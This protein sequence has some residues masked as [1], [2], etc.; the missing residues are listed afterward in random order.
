MTTA[1][2]ALAP[3]RRTPDLEAEQVTQLLPGE[4]VLVR[5]QTEEWSRVVAPWQA[6]SLDPAGYPGWVRRVHLDEEATGPLY[7]LPSAAD[8]LGTARSYL[9]TQYLWGG[10]TADGID[11]SGL[12]HVVARAH[13]MR[14]PRD[15]AD[16]HRRLAR[17]DLDEARVGDVYFFAR[18][19]ARVHHVALVAADAGPGVPRRVLHAPDTG[20][21]RV[22][23]EEVL[24]PERLATLHGAARLA[25]VASV[26]LDAAAG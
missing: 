3:V 18:A 21:E 25:S 17:V 11:C 12:V 6:S 4:P 2:R 10:L 24:P 16:Q 20:A 15:A 1:A 26:V 5:E 22:V 9:G 14:V 19:G 23:V 8:L 13:G 7:P